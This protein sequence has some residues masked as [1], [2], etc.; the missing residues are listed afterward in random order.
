MSCR[1]Y[2][3]T[4][5]IALSSLLLVTVAAFRQ[6]RDHAVTERLRAAR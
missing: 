3:V 6:P 4:A 2:F 5:A 1:K